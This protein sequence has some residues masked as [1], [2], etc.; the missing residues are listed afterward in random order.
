M[1]ILKK[2][3]GWGKSDKPQEV[4]MEDL[5]QDCN[6]F[7]IC[8]YDEGSDLDSKIK[9]KE[10]VINNGELIGYECNLFKKKNGKY[11]GG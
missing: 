2:R 5:C 7:H 3:K 4:R 8:L 6:N 9:Q 10:I 1:R 11:T